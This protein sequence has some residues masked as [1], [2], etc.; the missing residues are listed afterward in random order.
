MSDSMPI[1]PSSRTPAD[2]PNIAT[3]ITRSN[4][5][6]SAHAGALFRTYLI[7]TEVRTSATMLISPAQ[8]IYIAQRESLELRAVNQ[9]NVSSKK[10]PGGAILTS[11]GWPK[12][13]RRTTIV[14]LLGAHDFPNQGFK[15]WRWG[16]LV[17]HRFHRRN[18]LGLI[19]ILYQSRSGLFNE[20]LRGLFALF[21]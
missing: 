15:F 12:K 13:T 21:R 11:V 1:C 3:L 9:F 17:P 16:E 18:E 2:A 10:I 6:C 19:D 20:F 14:C 7:K 5:I 8:A 4:A